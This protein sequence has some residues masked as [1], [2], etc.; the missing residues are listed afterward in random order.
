MV[1]ERT[2]GEYG[3]AYRQVMTLETEY[4]DNVSSLCVF[5]VYVVLLLIVR[6][7]C[8]CVG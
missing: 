1:K 5:S 7:D 8:W 4:K 6:C 3:W 2:M